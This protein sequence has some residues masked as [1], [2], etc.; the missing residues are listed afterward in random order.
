MYNST[1]GYYDLFCGGTLI[2]HKVVITAAQ[3]FKTTDSYRSRIYTK[4]ISILKV[5]LGKY[6]RNINDPQDDLAQI[7]DVS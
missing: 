6:H 2:S 3:C 1:L 4:K 5:A 7:V